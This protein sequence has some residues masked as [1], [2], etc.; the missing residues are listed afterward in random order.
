MNTV[1]STLLVIAPE[2]AS[3]AETQRS[4]VIEIASQK[5]GSA[6]GDSQNL[7]TAYM[8]AHMLTL[9]GRKGNGGAVKSIKEGSLSITYTGSD[10]M[11]GLGST[12][13]G[14]EFKLMQKQ[15]LFAARTRSV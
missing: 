1:D 8:A 12:S 7:A 2:L 9:Q 10:F 3:V 14:Q 4:A 13:Y 5:V 15:C 6:F 11:D